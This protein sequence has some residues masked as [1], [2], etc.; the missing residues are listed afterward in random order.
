MGN[1]RISGLSNEN[2]HDGAD[3]VWH[4]FIDHQSSFPV[5]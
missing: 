5:S 1:V 3:N 4:T 2:L